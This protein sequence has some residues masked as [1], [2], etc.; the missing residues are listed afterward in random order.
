MLQ[1]PCLDSRH[2]HYV[3][4]KIDLAR[5]MQIL[6]R[7][8]FKFNDVIRNS[9]VHPF[10]VRETDFYADPKTVIKRKI[11]RDSKLFIVDNFADAAKYENVMIVNELFIL[12]PF[13]RL[14]LR[15]MRKP[16]DYEERLVGKAGDTLRELVISFGMQDLGYPVHMSGEKYLK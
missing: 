3:G 14:S 8:F 2:L 9:K 11:D 6:L 7:E 13:Y 4:L 12:W 10:Y 15:I 1:E 5:N 16:V